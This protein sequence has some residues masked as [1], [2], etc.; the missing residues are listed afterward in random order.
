MATLAKVSPA[1]RKYF[2]EAVGLDGARQRGG[3]VAFGH[4][5]A[6]KAQ[7]FGAF[8]APAARCAGDNFAL[9][10]FDLHMNNIR[11]AFLKAADFKLPGAFVTSW[12]YRSSPHEVCLPEYACV[13][14]GWNPATP[15][16]GKLMAGFFR[17]RYG[18]DDASLAAALLATT[19]IIPPSTRAAP[20]LDDTWTGWVMNGQQ[21]VQQIKEV[22]GGDREQTLATCRTWLE[23]MTGTAKEFQE[24]AAK[25]TRNQPELRHWD[26]SMQHLIHRLR[27]LQPLLRLAGVAYGRAGASDGEIA[28]WTKE[29][30]QFDRPRE[31]LR[32]AWADLYRDIH[33]LHHLKIELYNRFDAEREMIGLLLADLAKRKPVAASRP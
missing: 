19:P 32:G 1:Y 11:I 22:V 18:I 16:T 5:A 2:G 6:F 20:A 3:L 13:S 8:P 27:L 15:D 33:T 12:S 9:P 28:G 30:Q 24:A 26:L 17:Q 29:V 23:Q 31:V 4:A 10:R 25:A 21:Q 7:G 14:Y